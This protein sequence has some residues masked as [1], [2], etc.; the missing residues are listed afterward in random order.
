[1]TVYV[2]NSRNPY[3]RMLMSH[4]AAD[5]LEELHEMA[6]AIGLRRDWFQDGRLPHYDLCQ[7]KRRNAV[8]RG[9]VEVSAK[10]L[11]AIITKRKEGE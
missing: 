9:A 10:E 2:D 6:T 11:I 5:S 3:G 1:M 8:N 4:M 7:S